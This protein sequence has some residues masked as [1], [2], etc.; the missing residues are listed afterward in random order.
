MNEST[1]SFVSRMW[2]RHFGN[3]LEDDEMIVYTFENRLFGTPRVIVMNFHVST[4]DLKT[5]VNLDNTY[6]E[7]N[8]WKLV[9]IEG[10]ASSNRKEI[11]E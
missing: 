10:F 8:Q 6:D 4:Q 11:K 5:L 3:H 1:L 9:S 7:I 2:F